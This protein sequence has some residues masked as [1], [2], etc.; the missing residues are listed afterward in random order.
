MTPLRIRRAEIADVDA[1]AS[2]FTRAISTFDFVKKIHTAE[3]DRAFWRDV[4]FAE[5]DIWVAERDGRIL[6]IITLRPGW[7]THLHID[8]DHWGH[9][10]GS[11]LIAHAQSDNTRLQL[12]CFQAN[13][14]ARALYE[15]HGF[16][17][18]EFTDGQTNEERTPDVRYVWSR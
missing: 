5:N 8:P 15:R 9:G 17:A 2:V 10:T 11:A 4:V 14:R 3:E 6:G 18:A 13:A 12:W 1:V 16:V 7:I